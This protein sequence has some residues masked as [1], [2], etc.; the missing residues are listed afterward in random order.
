[1]LN[2][3]TKNARAIIFVIPTMLNIIV[4]NSVEIAINN[5]S[6]PRIDIRSLSRL[7]ILSLFT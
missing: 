6:V 4:K 7:I 2:T 1:M 5:V 3:I